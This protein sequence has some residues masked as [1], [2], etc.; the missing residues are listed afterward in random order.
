MQKVSSQGSPNESTTSNLEEI[1]SFI[2]DNTK[3]DLPQSSNRNF[4][5][6]ECLTN[7]LGALSSPLLDEDL[8]PASGSSPQEFMQSPA[9]TA[10]CVN[11]EETSHN[12]CVN[13]T[14][15]SIGK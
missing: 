7:K 13:A 4:S 2:Y 12:R 3:N 9:T 10:K 1:A 5:F 14:E 8:V 11:I 15:I 6:Y